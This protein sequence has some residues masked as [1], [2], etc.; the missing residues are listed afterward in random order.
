[1]FK[2]YDPARV[3]ITWAGIL[4]QGPAAGT[5]VS[6]ER[7]DDG[8]KM[9]I[10]SAGDVTRVRNRNRSGSVTVTL[11]AASPTNDLLS[12]RVALDEAFG[13]GYGPLQ[14]KD[15][16]GTTLLLAEFAWVRKLPTVEAA[17]EAS[18][19]EW[20]FDCASLDMNG[21]GAVV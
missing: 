2:N 17:D 10:G 18:N 4:I 21:G 13:T 7:A 9:D 11:Q 1:M 19:R 20:I 12:S 8:F 16:N 15:L 14:V 5:F 6:A 3:V